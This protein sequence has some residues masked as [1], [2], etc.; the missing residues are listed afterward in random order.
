MDAEFIPA[1]V[2]AKIVEDLVVHNLAQN[3][4]G[5]ASCRATDQTGNDGAS[6]GAAGRPD[7]T[8]NQTHVRTGQSESDAAR[9]AGD[10]ADRATRFTSV[11]TRFHA[12]GLAFGAGWDVGRVG[13]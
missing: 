2:T 13:W 8:S 12:S 3:G 4:T 10:G 1:D 5:S 7:R 9:H 6:Q 11:I